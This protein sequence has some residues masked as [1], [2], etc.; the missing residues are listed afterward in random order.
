MGRNVEIKAR[1]DDR[2]YLI[3]KINKI[4]TKPVA[5]LEQRDSFFQCPVGRLKLRQFGTGEAE[6]IYYQRA[7]QQGPKLSSYQ[8]CP[9][10]HADTLRATLS[11]AWGT[12]GE[13]RK[14][15]HLYWCGQTRIHVDQVEG[16]GDFVEFEVVLDHQQS[17][18]D[19]QRIA[20]ELLE[21][22]GIAKE[23]L[24]EGAYIDLLN[25]PAG[26]PSHSPAR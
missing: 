26:H 3:N 16:L 22:L 21:Q 23:Q 5:I 11:A 19:G 4:S 15:R 2:D 1:V 13:V 10:S 7:D 24:I 9:V 17:A 18:E 8:R 12:R 20:A 6:L 25:A 14:I